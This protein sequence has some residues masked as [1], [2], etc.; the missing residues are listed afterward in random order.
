MKEVAVTE[1]SERFLIASLESERFRAKRFASLLK[2]S[3]FWL[4]DYLVSYFV[5]VFT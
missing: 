1:K 5:K 3:L 4:L 2:R